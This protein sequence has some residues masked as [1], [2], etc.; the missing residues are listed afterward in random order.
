MGE[1]R[2]LLLVVLIFTLSSFVYASGMWVPVPMSGDVS[3][4]Q[5]FHVM[6]S[7]DGI[8]YDAG[9][10]VPPYSNDPSD[11]NMFCAIH[12]DGG[13]VG[14]GF[15]N[16]SAYG[17]F[18]VEDLK[19][20]SLLINEKNNP[21]SYDGIP[22]NARHFD[23]NCNGDELFEQNA[24]PLNRSLILSRY[25]ENGV[26]YD[27][28]YRAENIDNFDIIALN[29]SDE[30]LL[31]FG[32]YIIGT[33]IDSNSNLPIP[34]VNAT[35]YFKNEKGTNIPYLSYISNSTGSFTTL[36]PRDIETYY[37]NYSD[38][39]MIPKTSYIIVTKHPLYEDLVVEVNL[40]APRPDEKF[41][42]Q[43]YGVCESDCTFEGGNI[44]Q[45]E[46]QGINGC[47]FDN[48]VLDSSIVADA[49]DSLPVNSDTIFDYGLKSYSA[50]T[51]TGVVSEIISDSAVSSSSSCP[52]DKSAWRSEHLVLRDGK[53]AKMVVTYCR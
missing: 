27:V 38:V 45:K 24:N 32:S 30:T 34:D 41:Y 28:E 35:L 17:I 43:P 3:C 14:F 15:I 44:C 18:T 1:M 40:N 22:A 33:F 21:W 37:R 53:V 52:P 6:C 9:G 5:N 19:N 26:A 12:D 7:E 46:C 51:C 31:N 23:E 25:I 49:L 50:T 11:T 10:K 42:L 2:I 36:N 4:N 29:Q 20:S 8:N 39:R 48:T 13:T 47:F 16:G